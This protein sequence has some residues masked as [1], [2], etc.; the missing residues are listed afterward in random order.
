M[1]ITEHFLIGCNRQYLKAK[2]VTAEGE[3]KAPPKPLTPKK[4]KVVTEYFTL[5]AR[6]FSCQAKKKD[7]RDFFAPLKPDSIRLP[8]KVKG[9]AYIGF[10]SEKDWKKALDKHR[11]FHGKTCDH[12]L[13][14]RRL[15]H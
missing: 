12:S 14:F 13:S 2:V 11:S 15:M 10:A 4:E 6:G 5:K 7:V 8:P 3:E 9:V 1:W